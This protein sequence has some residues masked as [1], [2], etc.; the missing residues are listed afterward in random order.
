MLD[1]ALKLHMLHK[2][3]S[4]TAV[5]GKGEITGAVID[6]VTESSVVGVGGVTGAGEDNEAGVGGGDGTGTCVG[7]G[8]EDTEA[9]SGAERFALAAWWRAAR[10]RFLSFSVGPR[11]RGWREA[12]V[13][14]GE[15]GGGK[16]REVGWEW[17]AP[18]FPRV[19][20]KL[21]VARP[22]LVERLREALPP[23]AQTLRNSVTEAP[24]NWALLLEVMFTSIK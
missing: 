8:G 4:M 19:Q 3:S 20:L 10:R 15:G 11:W 7:G 14:G 9:D 22:S 1:T 5:E 23:R 17:G 18:G 13:V 6:E 2:V 12:E 24:T 21:T 16:E